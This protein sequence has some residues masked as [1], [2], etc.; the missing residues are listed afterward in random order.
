MGRAFACFRYCLVAGAILLGISGAIMSVCA[1]YFIYQLHE[2]APLTPSHVCGSSATLLA[3]GV[4][5]CG[6]GWFAWQFLDFSNKG[7]V[8]VLAIALAIIVLIETSVGIWTLVRHEQIDTL[9]AARHQEIFALAIT[10]DKP[11]WDHMQSALRCCGID[12]SSDY[13]GK[14][15]IPWSCCNTTNQETDND[16]TAGACTVMYKRGCQHVVLSRTRS[17]LLHVFLLALCSVLLQ[18]SFIACTTC[19]VRIFKDRMERRAS[20]MAARTSLQDMPEAD[21]KNKL[22]IRQSR[23]LHNS[24]DP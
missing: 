15:E 12:G 22:L 18:I 13:R 19:Y 24:D 1:G 5:I 9:S 21:T 6:I 20:Q 16:S 4:I 8:I 10:D 17:I 7:Q 3:M 2:Y 11:I 14:G 23:Y